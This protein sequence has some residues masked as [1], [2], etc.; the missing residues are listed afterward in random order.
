MRWWWGSR[1]PAS[2]PTWSACSRR[3]RR[4]RPTLAITNDPSSPLASAAD[5]VLALYAGEE[6]A[7]AATK[8]YTCQLAVVAMLSEALAGSPTPVRVWPFPTRRRRRWA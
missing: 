3:R 1:N 7:V 5:E 4:R 2:R 8:T 6:K